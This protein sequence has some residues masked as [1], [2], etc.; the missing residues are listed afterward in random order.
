MFFKRLISIHT[1]L[2]KHLDKLHPFEHAKTI[3]MHNEFKRLELL[4]VNLSEMQ[5]IESDSEMRS[6][7]EEERQETL[8]QQYALYEK[9]K[10]QVLQCDKRDESN[11]ML[12]IRAG[13]GGQEAALF[14]S[15]LWEMYERFCDVKGWN[16]KG[17]SSSEFEGGGLREGIALIEGTRVFSFLK[18][19]GGV[20]RV[21]RV[22]KTENGG[23][24]HTSTVS[25]AVLPEQEE[26]SID[27]QEKDLKWEA[28]RAQGPGG[29]HV[30]TTNSAVRLTHIPSGI[31]IISQE[32]RS[33]QLNKMRALTV[34]KYRM[35][36]IQAD[37][38]EKE[39]QEWRSKLIGSS[40]RSEKI[41]TFNF[42][43]DRI[44]DH[45]IS[46]T[47][48]NIAKFME[49]HVLDKLIHALQEQEEQD[50]LDSL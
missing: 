47:C 22:P 7:L 21:Q 46:F 25:V 44:T 18:F 24:V 29:Q 17:I 36:K 48:H 15:E 38:V 37:S 50:K 20:H 6:L 2:Q 35:A 4:Q 31:A 3:A 11:A 33:Q 1:K 26:I 41:R 40:S 39:R 16:F 23:R 10:R 9:I 28:F 13:T 45:R 43:Q 34:L 42:P 30:N 19:E 14:A 32:E 27:L 5:Q 12:E 49:G 8:A